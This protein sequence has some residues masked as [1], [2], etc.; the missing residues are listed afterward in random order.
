MSQADRGTLADSVLTR[1]SVH[2]RSESRLSP[3][4]TCPAW[5]ASVTE[6]ELHWEVLFVGF[7]SGHVA[8][9]LDDPAMEDAESE[10]GCKNGCG[11]EDKVLDA[12]LDP[13][14]SD[15]R[16]RGHG[17]NEGEVFEDRDGK[18][19]LL[20]WR[21]A[22]EG[23]DLDSQEEHVSEQQAHAGG[24]EQQAGC[25]R[26]CE[27][28]RRSEGAECEPGA[29]GDDHGPEEYPDFGGKQLM[30]G[31]GEM[32]GPAVDDAKDP[33]SLLIAGR[34]EGNAQSGDGPEGNYAD[35]RADA[36]G[37]DFRADLA[38]RDRQA[39]NAGDDNGE[40][41]SS[42]E[43]Q[44]DAIPLYAKQGLTDEVEY[45]A[46]HGRPKQRGMEE[47]MQG[48]RDPDT[49]IVRAGAHDKLAHPAQVGEGIDEHGQRDSDEQ[50]R[51]SDLSA[52]GIDG[53]GRRAFEQPLIDAE[54][55]EWRIV[56]R[57]AASGFEEDGNRTG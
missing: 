48:T 37:R 28:L 20:S 57:V 17:G 15:N 51:A 32:R 44:I 14:F 9:F 41:D 10:M 50:R 49:R 12:C 16:E 4:F 54:E 39:K 3:P 47:P 36:I 40:A 13:R 52:P 23:D 56:E 30:H 25:C 29:E 43:N 18:V 38:V 6:A 33:A 5:T 7:E 21:L 27:K 26:P 11:G 53:Q 45:G 55:P 46:A 42:V 1:E 8:V 2:R 35:S 34:D 19:G 31:G 24:D 22:G